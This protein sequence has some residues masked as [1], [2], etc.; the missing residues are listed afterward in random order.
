MFCKQD[1]IALNI[2]TEKI[3]VVFNTDDNL[4][5]TATSA[6][7]KPSRFQRKVG[8]VVANWAFAVEMLLLL[9]EK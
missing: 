6:V 3:P 5:L 2:L 7:K 9:V 8:T 4:L 1:D